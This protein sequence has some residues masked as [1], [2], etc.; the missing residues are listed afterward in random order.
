MAG[1][2]ILLGY[3]GPLWPPSIGFA[4]Q[5]IDDLAHSA[6]IAALAWALV[7]RATR[8]NAITSKCFAAVEVALVLGNTRR[9]AHENM[10]SFQFP[11]LLRFRDGGHRRADYAGICYS[12]HFQSDLPCRGRARPVGR[13]FDCI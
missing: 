5:K 9:N 13:N 10:P 11:D 12:H 4:K 7:N 2:F 8:Q 6:K 3:P 1:S